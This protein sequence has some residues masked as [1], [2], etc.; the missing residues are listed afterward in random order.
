[1]FGR[2]KRRQSIKDLSAGKRAAMGGAA[3]VQLGLLAAA[4]LDLLK[5]PAE[6]VRGPKWGWRAATLVNFVGPL[7][8]FLF[9]RRRSPR[10]AGD[11]LADAV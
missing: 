2:S 3:L 9:G 10:M 4:Q 6:R 8:Y 11:S 1:M 7:A 5:R